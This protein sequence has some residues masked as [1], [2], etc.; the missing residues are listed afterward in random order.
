MA[1]TVLT[2]AQEQRH[3]IIRSQ[4]DKFGKSWSEESI[5]EKENEKIR[6]MW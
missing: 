4:C 3:G 5:A 1:G 6:E 2:V